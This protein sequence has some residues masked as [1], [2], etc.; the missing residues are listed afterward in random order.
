MKTVKLPRIYKIQNDETR[1]RMDGEET[2][3][4]GVEMVCRLRINE[5][6]G[7]KKSGPHQASRKM[8][9]QENRE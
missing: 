4:D 3:I 5:E 8:G 1:R 6:D 9:D 7:P 2:I